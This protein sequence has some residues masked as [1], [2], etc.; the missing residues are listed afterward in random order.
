MKHQPVLPQRLNIGII[1]CI[2]LTVVLFFPQLTSATASEVRVGPGLFKQEGSNPAGI[3]VGESSFR[4]TFLPVD[5]LARNNTWPLQ[6]FRRYA[7]QEVP[8]SARDDFLEALPGDGFQLDVSSWSTVD[9]G[10]G[11]FAANLGLRTLSTATIAQDFLELFLTGVET[12]RP[13]TFDGTQIGAVAYGDASFGLSV[14]LGPLRI[15]GRYHRLMGAHYSHASLTGGGKISDIPGEEGW[16]GNL[17]LEVDRTEGEGVHGEGAA[18]DVGVIANLTD[19]LAIGMAVMDIGEI[20]WNV[21][22]EVYEGTVDPDAE[23]DESPDFSLIGSAVGE[24]LTWQL[25]RRYEASL[26][27]QL[28]QSLH[29]GVAYIHT[30]HDS[31]AGYVQD[32]ESRVQ[33]MLSW[34]GLGIVPLG[35]GAAYTEIDGL[36]LSGEAGLR[37][38]PVRT[39]ARLTN[40]QLLLGD[41]PAK[42]LGFTFDMGIAF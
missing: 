1:A 41:S 22:S 32:E 19:R 16:N 31:Q 7:E 40:V 17:R 23:A 27:Y 30:T 9:L 21:T 34:S 24:Q 2:I 29:L 15:G 28:T 5:L 3:G 39:R 4:F 10:V 26:G 6:T 14:G 37:L 36:T 35:I 25:P 13:Y 18:Y 8:E 12:N 38:G 11:S 33:G 20:V 42:G